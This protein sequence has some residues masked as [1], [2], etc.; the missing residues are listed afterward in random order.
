MAQLAT[1][2]HCDHELLLPE[3]LS[4]GASVRCPSCDSSFKPKDAELREIAAVEVIT[5]AS[6]EESRTPT[7]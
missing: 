2:P 3:G 6:D 5:P 7:R 4:A 1:C